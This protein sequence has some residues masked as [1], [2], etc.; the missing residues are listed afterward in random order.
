MELLPLSKFKSL[1]FQNLFSELRENWAVNLR[2][3]YGDPLRIICSLIDSSALSGFVVLKEGIP[4]GYTFY[5][6]EGTNGLIGDCFVAKR[7]AGI[8]VEESLL[9]KTVEALRQNS[10]ITRIESQFINFRSWPMERFFRQQGFRCYER[11]F[12]LSHCEGVTV[13]MVPNEI[14]LSPWQDYDLEAAAQLTAYSYQNTIDREISFSYQSVQGCRDFLSNLIVKPGCGTFL[15]N[16]SFTAWHR[17]SKEMV[18]FVLTSCISRM[19]GHIPQILV[20]PQFQG[21]GI[22]SYLLSHAI[23]ALR[24]NQ[25]RTVSLTVTAQNKPALSLYQRFDFGILLHFQ[26][27]VWRRDEDPVCCKQTDP[28]SVDK[29]R[30]LA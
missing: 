4:A 5:L 13:G 21:R 27:A 17:P 2:W 18:G 24:S 7:H 1:N 3:D 25:F 26:T 9:D 14:G 6:E 29:P 22:G 8:G 20:S 11:Y 12:M 23:V 28:T 16:T 30:L 15:R 19:N 10:N